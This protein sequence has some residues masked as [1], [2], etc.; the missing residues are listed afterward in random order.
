LVFSSKPQTFTLPNTSVLV[1]SFDWR[2]RE[3]TVLNL[4]KLFTL[5]CCCPWCNNEV[6]PYL[7]PPFTA[8]LI[9]WSQPCFPKL[10]KI[11]GRVGSPDFQPIYILRSSCL[12]NGDEAEARKRERGEGCNQNQSQHA[13][14]SSFL[15][16]FFLSSFITFKLWSFI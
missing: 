2:Q 11:H 8:V 14:S 1:S 10:K 6:S 13:A 3:G 9:E 12:R 16:C 4:P 15:L 7:K 5:C